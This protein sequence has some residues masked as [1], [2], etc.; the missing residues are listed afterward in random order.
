MGFR[1]AGICYVYHWDARNPGK[2][3]R[4]DMRVDLRGH[5]PTG[6][7]WGYSGSGPAQLALALCAHALA[8]DERA[9]AIYQLFKRKVVTGL[10]R[11]CWSLT[12]DAVCDTVCLL[13]NERP[14]R[15]E[16]SHEEGQ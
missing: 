10:D 2:P 7:E 1:I 8:D 3:Q 12:R 15:K 13:E 16:D 5:S 14:T 9:L 4:L 6:P 11:A